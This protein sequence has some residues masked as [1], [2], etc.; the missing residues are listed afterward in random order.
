MSVMLLGR[1]HAGMS[2]PPA[3]KLNVY[4]SVQVP[5]GKGVP[6]GVRRG[7][8]REGLCSLGCG[9]QTGN[10]LSPISSRRIERAFAG[11]E[12]IVAA[13]LR[14]LKLLELNLGSMV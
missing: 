9:Q 4:A 11:P 1:E 10:T 2:Q 7:L 3:D 5:D 6:E 12:P 14:P 13:V 8:V